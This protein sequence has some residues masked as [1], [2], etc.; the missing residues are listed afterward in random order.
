[1]K[2]TRSG[3]RK[4]SCRVHGDYR[5]YEHLL[6]HYKSW[7]IVWVSLAIVPY[8][9]VIIASNINL[10]WAMYFLQSLLSP[11]IVPLLLSITWA[12][13]TSQAVIAGTG[14]CWKNINNTTKFWGAIFERNPH[15]WNTSKFFP[16]LYFAYPYFLQN[17]TQHLHSSNWALVFARLSQR[18]NN[19]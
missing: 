13:C 5:Q 18:M 12:K 8:G 9:L 11:V 4:Y 10:H 14:I 15:S 2:S 19:E 6:M 17:N 1:M 3:Q 16:Y 7:C